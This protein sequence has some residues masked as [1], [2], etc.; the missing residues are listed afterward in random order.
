MEN[1]VFRFRPLE[2]GSNKGPIIIF[3]RFPVLPE[4]SH[5]TRKLT[6]FPKFLVK[7]ISS[8]IFRPLAHIFSQTIRSPNLSGG[9]EFLFK[10]ILAIRLSLGSGVYLRAMYTTVAR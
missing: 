2:L 3:R 1:I 9:V 4:M 6:K 7:N 10:G 8:E 5:R